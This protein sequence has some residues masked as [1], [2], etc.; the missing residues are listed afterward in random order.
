MADRH[1]SQRRAV[2]ADAR[3]DVLLFRLDV[4]RW[5]GFP[6]VWRGEGELAARE[7]C[8]KFVVIPAPIRRIRQWRRA[9]W[10]ETPPAAVHGI[11][12]IT[13][14]IDPTEIRAGGRWPLLL[15]GRYVERGNLD[16]AAVDAFTPPGF[17]KSPKSCFR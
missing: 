6:S 15:G 10:C 9:L 3:N 11:P 16:K 7:G 12:E 4:G 2:L 5:I 8:P 17:V 1:V 14:S 13:F